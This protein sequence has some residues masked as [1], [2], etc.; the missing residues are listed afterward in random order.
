MSCR[1]EGDDKVSVRGFRQR[2]GSEA[3]NR[4]WGCDETGKTGKRAKKIVV[5]R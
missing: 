4:G 5:G 3:L 2:R 1:I